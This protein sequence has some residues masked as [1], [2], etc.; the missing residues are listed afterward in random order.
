[1]MEFFSIVL[2]CDHNHIGGGKGG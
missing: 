1:M 2:A